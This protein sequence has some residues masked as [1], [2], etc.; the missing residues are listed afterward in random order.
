MRAQRVDEADAVGARL[1]HADDAAAADID[2]RLAHRFQRVDPVREG[3][4][5]DDLGIFLRRGVDIVVVIIEAR[6]RRACRACFGVSMPSVMQVS[7]PMARTPFT[8][9]TSA[10][11]SLVL[12]IAPGRAHAEAARAADPWPAPPPA[13]PPR[14]SIS[15]VALR[16]RLGM[17]R[18]VAIA[19]ILGAA[20]GLDRQQG[21]ELH[22]VAADDAR[23]GSSARS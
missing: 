13:A 7:M 20:A 16:P 12:G 6:L 1:A 3:A 2:P 18:L 22:L 10:G 17:D 11:M 9:S 14:T 19:A 23:G 21:R 15:L 5:G 4:R 8:I